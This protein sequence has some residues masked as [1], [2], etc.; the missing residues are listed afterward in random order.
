MT[1]EIIYNITNLSQSI[2]T[3]AKRI[4]V[5]GWYA[6]LIMSEYGKCLI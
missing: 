5:S 1:P 3:D 2:L 4:T 6:G